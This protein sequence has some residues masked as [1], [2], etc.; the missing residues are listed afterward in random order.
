MFETICDA[1]AKLFQNLF[2]LSIDAI[3]FYVNFRIVHP[4]TAY[5]SGERFPGTNGVLHP[6][7]VAARA[8]QAL[9]SEY[10]LQIFL[11]KGFQSGHK[12]LGSGYSWWFVVRYFIGVKNGIAIA[13]LGEEQLAIDTKILVPGLF[14]D[15]CVKVSHRPILLGP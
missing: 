14:A 11:G 8:S 13:L 1:H 9:G 12:L 4:R 5:L 7:D 6:I 15:Q 2:Q 3:R 10:V